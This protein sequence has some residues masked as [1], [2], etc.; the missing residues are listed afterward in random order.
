MCLQNPQ[1]LWK[2]KPLFSEIQLFACYVTRHIMIGVL[3]VI[4]PRKDFEDDD[5]DDDDDAVSD[6]TLT[7]EIAVIVVL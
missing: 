3:W 1:L 2:Q 4:Y 5:D 7:V 6:S